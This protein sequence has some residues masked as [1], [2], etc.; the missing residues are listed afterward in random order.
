LRKTSLPARSG[1]TRAESGNGRVAVAAYTVYGEKPVQRRGKTQPFK[2]AARASNNPQLFEDKCIVPEG[3]RKN[4][5]KPTARP[6]T[7]CTLTRL[8]TRCSN[9]QDTAPRS[10]GVCTWKLDQLRIPKQHPAPQLC[11]TGCLRN[12]S[13][14]AG[15]G[16]AAIKARTTE[17]P[18]PGTAA[19]TRRPRHAPGMRQ[20]SCAQSTLRC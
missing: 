6:G 2:A 3:T 18:P 16:L 14:T 19:R 20:W 1:C 12:L 10:V 13:P 7:L 5:R 17:K 15:R 11:N 4:G 8:Q 9:W